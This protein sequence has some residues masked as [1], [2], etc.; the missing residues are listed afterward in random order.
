M[1]SQSYIPEYVLHGTPRDIGLK[2]GRSL[3]KQIESN[4][5]FYRS[6]WK[7]SEEWIVEYCSEMQQ[8][9]EKLAP[10]FLEEMQGIAEG[11]GVAL[12]WIIALNSR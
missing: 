1:E 7:L 11:S 3:S 8:R 2:H 12:T 5:A 4:V 10:E 6:L 9:L